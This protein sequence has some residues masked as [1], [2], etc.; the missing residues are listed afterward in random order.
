ML[1]KQLRS[2]FWKLLQNL[3]VTKYLEEYGTN[4]LNKICQLLRIFQKNPKQ[5]IFGKISKWH[6]DQ[7]IQKL[8]VSQLFPHAY[9]EKLPPPPETTKLTKM[10][11]SFYFSMTSNVM[12]HTKMSKL[13]HVIT[14]AQASLVS[15]SEF[16]F[17]AIRAQLS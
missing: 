3:T 12:C 17:F 9:C 2:L 13:V 5:K 4:N 15:P 8:V 14:L 1:G 11:L 16:F 7:I 6:G 10:G